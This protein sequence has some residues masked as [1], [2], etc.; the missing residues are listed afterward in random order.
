MQGKHEIDM[1][2]GSLAPKIMKFAIPYMLT[3]MLQIMF[4][5]ADNAVI[6]AFDG[7]NALAAVGS[8]GSITNF[9]V[10]LFMGLSVGTNVI[11]SK[12]IGSSQKKMC[13]ET[14]HTAMCLSFAIG[15]VLA[16][17]GFFLA[18]TFLGFLNCPAEVID[19]AD[20]YLKIYFMGMPAISAYN[21]SSSI[22]RSKGDTQRPLIYLTVAGIVNVALNL[23]LVIVFKLST[24]GVAIATTVS[25]YISAFLTIRALTKEEDVCRL[26]LR[27]LRIIPHVAVKLLKIGVPA[28]IQGLMFSISNISIQGSVNTFGANA[29]AGVGAASS[30]NNIVWNTISAFGQASLA[31]TAQNYGAKKFDRIKRVYLWSIVLMAICWAVVTLVIRLNAV[32]LLKLFLPTNEHAMEYAKTSCLLLTTTYVV[33][34]LMEVSVGML[35]GLG[36]SAVPAVI[37]VFGICGIRLV[38]LATAFKKFHTF[39]CL[40]IS[41]PT[42]W[43]VTTIALVIYFFFVY[44]KIIRIHR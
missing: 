3:G 6:G 18:R 2:T 8:T 37:S 30:L 20:I 15:I 9:A 10:N 29:M 14:V 44:K 25:Q 13:E 22:L 28:S 33:A 31:F 34:G 36:F 43:A 21:F 19:L 1:T 35:R 17:G 23:L 32:S 16:F 41:Y 27:R 4:N 38:W 5:A 12:A 26:V 42:T 39:I 7:S 11:L 24:A 40:Y